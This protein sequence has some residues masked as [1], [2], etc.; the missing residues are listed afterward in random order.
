MA[1]YRDESGSGRMFGRVDP[2]CWVAAAPMILVAVA[3]AFLGGLVQAVVLVCIAGLLVLFDSWVNRNAPPKDTHRE[4][5]AR[6]AR[7]GAS[8]RSPP[9]RRRPG[10]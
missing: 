7:S 9:P 1:R 5:A 2:F 3:I 4:P 10:R 8:R 6:S